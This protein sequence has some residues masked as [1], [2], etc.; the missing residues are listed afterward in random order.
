MDLYKVKKDK[1]CER[2]RRTDDLLNK[3]QGT[4]NTNKEQGRDV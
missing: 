1:K 2:C 4:R 3:E